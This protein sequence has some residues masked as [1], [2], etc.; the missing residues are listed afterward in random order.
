[1]M[2]QIV[3]P[4]TIVCL[5]Y[6]LYHIIRG[7]RRQAVSVLV[8]H[9]IQVIDIISTTKYSVMRMGACRWNLGSLIDGH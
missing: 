4:V 6:I 2:N 1:M 7:W 3:I 9:A 8:R 5:G